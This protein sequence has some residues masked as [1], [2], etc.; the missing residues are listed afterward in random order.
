MDT[1]EVRVWGIHTKDDELFLKENVIAIGWAVMGD[2]SKIT[3]D[4]EAFRKK[5]Y[6]CYP[7]ASKQSIATNTGQIYR[8]AHEMQV[9]DYIVFPSKNDRMINIGI[10]ES[11]YFYY[12]NAL[13]NIFDYVNRRK[14]KWIK[15]LPRTLFSQGALFEAGTA[16]SIFSVKNFAE[17]FLSALDKDF[18]KNV[19]Q[20]L[21]EDESI[22]ATAEDIR[23]NTKDF[24]LKEL[25][26][27]L[28]G[29]DLEG[30]V[31]N[32]LHAMGYNAIVSKQGGDRGIDIIAFKDALPPRV[33]VQVKSGDG[34]IKETT[35]HSLRGAMAE[36]DYGL[37][38]TLST[39]AKNARK[40]LD[41]HPI[42]RGIDGAELV[43][44]ILEYYDDL[45]EKY[46]R[47]IPLDKVYIPVIK[48]VEQ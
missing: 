37:F 9:G 31:A 16:M 32:L 18:K 39:Y 41:E 29:Y 23:E 27:Q 2:L 38:V 45:D 48:D 3:P 12:P 22:A 36:G 20:I 43:E 19:E 28:K 42:I 8:F 7:E 21:I 26:R 24:I 10:I 4:R 15:H 6:E 33:V 46:K 35:I 44:L 34:D 30:F 5:M 47:I 1:K 40:Y 17:E 11:D 14:V 25:R 13:N